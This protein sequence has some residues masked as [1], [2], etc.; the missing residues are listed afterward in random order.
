MLSVAGITKRFGAVLANDAVSF[1]VAAGE[2]LGVLGENG[3]GKSTVMN[4]AGGLLTPDAGEIRIDGR[5]VAIDSPR[6]AARIGIG[7]VHQHFMLVEALTVEENLALGLVRAPRIDYAALRT[8]I[9]ALGIPLDYTARVRDLPIAAQ[10]RVEIVKALARDPRILI[11]DEPTAVLAPAERDA[12]FALVRKLKARGVATILISHKLEDILELCE[13]VVVMRQGRVVATANAAGLARAD[14]VRLVVGEDVPAP[15]RAA[16]SPGAVVLEAHDLDAPGVRAATFTLHTGEV[17]GLAGVDGNGQSEL[18][19][20]IA[21]MARASSGRLVYRLGGRT[22]EGLCPAAR[23]RRAGLTHIAEDRLRHAAIGSLDLAANWLLTH[24]PFQGRFGITAT[25][26]AGASVE[27]AITDYAIRARGPRA[28]MRELS[29]GNQ[30]KLVIARELARNPDIVI[31]AYPTRGLDVRTQ[32]FV[33]ARLTA[34]R[35][36]GAAVLLVSNDLAEVM[37]IADRVM[38]MSAGRIHGPVDT[39]ATTLAELGAWMTAR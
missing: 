30:Q 14:L 25:G 21:G 12:L 15:S 6:T 11:L 7:M 20:L 2:V 1:D 33:K 27:T 10:Q 32:A 9:D 8:R 26:A 29:G 31:A 28:A 39:A 16:R 22:L 24:L 35:D 18:V 38:V 3:A 5:A 17:L 13:R 19:Q 4:I 34:A 23:L 37:E 36:R